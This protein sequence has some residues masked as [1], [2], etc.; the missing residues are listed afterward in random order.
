MSS[1][2]SGSDVEEVSNKN[3][4]VC[5]DNDDDAESSDY[6]SESGDEQQFDD[7]SSVEYD[8]DDYSIDI[9]NSY[10]NNE[11]TLED[12]MKLT[13]KVGTKKMKV[14][15]EKAKRIREGKPVQ[16]SGDNDEKSL[17]RKNKVMPEGFQSKKS[18]LDTDTK[19]QK[20]T[21][22]KLKRKN[23]NAPEECSSRRPKGWKKPLFQPYHIKPQQSR[24][25]R[26]DALCGTEFN[27]AVFDKRYDFLTDIEQNEIRTL[28]KGLKKQKNEK[29]KKMIKELIASKQQKLKAK[30]ERI[31][32]REIEQELKSEEKQKVAEGKKPYFM[33]ESELNRKVNEKMGIKK[34]SGKTKKWREQRKIRKE[35][36]KLN[37]Y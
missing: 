5:S 16:D 2:E 11:G 29:K 21:N 14:L 18:K 12:I 13:D 20:E 23:K 22:E 32:R 37:K 6:D 27:Q 35:M 10:H 19:D 7:E 24:D 34:S 28:Q 1:S 30:E 3:I 25:P 4:E 17:K 15:E 8:S 31:K 36:S 26:F 33:K 9:I